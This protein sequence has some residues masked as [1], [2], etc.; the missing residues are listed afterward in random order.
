MEKIACKPCQIRFLHLV[1][2]LWDHKMSKNMVMKVKI[3]TVLLHHQ[4]R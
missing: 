2:R 1:Q 3:G 4:Q